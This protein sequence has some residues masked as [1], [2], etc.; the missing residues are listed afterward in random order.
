MRHIFILFFVVIFLQSNAKVRLPALV[1]DGMVLQRNTVLNIWGWANINEKVNVRFLNQKL[2]TRADKD[3][4]WAINLKPVTEGGP[5][6]LN[7]EGENTITLKDILVGDVWVCGGQS[8]MGWKLS[9]GVEGKDDAI[10]TADFPMIRL[11]TVKESISYKVKDDV[12]S[13]KGW[14]HCSPANVGDFSAV[15][16]FF[17]REL[18]KKHKIPVGLISSNRG[19]SPAE[20]WLSATTIKTLPDYSKQMDEL[21]KLSPADLRSRF[22]KRLQEWALKTVN[23]D[24]GFDKQ[25]WYD[26]QLDTKNWKSMKLPSSWENTPL[27]DYDGMVWFRK[28]I[29][30]APADAG[31]EL[32]LFLA[33][34]DDLD[35]TWFN[36]T[37]IGGMESEKIREYKVP[38]NLVK[39]GKNIVTMRVLDFGGGGG[40]NGK[41]EEM[42]AQIGTKTINLA[43]DWIYMPGNK[44]KY[45]SG[46][47]PRSPEINASELAVLYNGMIA[48]LTPFKIKGVIFYQGEGNVK[49]VEKYYPLFTALIRDWRSAWNYDFP[50]I[51]TQLSTNNNPDTIPQESKLAQLR[52]T[53]LKALVL[54]NTAMAVTVDI[55]SKDVHPLNK[56]DVGKRLALAAEKV[57]YKKDVVHSGPIYQSMQVEG[58]KIR[59]KFTQIGSGLQTKDKYGYLRGF[60]I[61]GAD[62]K[63]VWAKAVIEDNTVVVYSDAVKNPTAVRYAWSDNPADA[64]LYNKEGLPASPFR[65]E[66]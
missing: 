4:K 54:P 65:T 11:F 42:R 15:A 5:Y 66:K 3:G 1:G 19:G 62:M 47:P 36:G 30:I 53:Q 16:F 23:N 27:P 6:T 22:E 59:L 21:E 63:F 17:G 37:K 43:G 7:I 46:W 50:F 25:K 26:L 24:K 20:A 12:V 13:E 8:N 60:A 56:L 49:S 57:A 61:A 45:T 9:W 34:P 41:P 39:A 51:F 31:K 32:T 48:P 55:G 52:E 18:Y 10:A 58:D 2:I 29:E 38:G 44:S 33:R 14:E 35:S 64:N 28:E 40:V